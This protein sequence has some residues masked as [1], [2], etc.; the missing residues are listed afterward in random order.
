MATTSMQELMARMKAQK[1]AEKVGVSNSQPSSGEVK[2]ALMD[3]LDTVTDKPVHV[4]YIG[5]SIESSP[6]T[7]NHADIMLI[8]NRIIKLQEAMEKDIPEYASIL[9]TIH[10][11]LSKDDEL[12]H[13]M[14]EEEVGI[15]LRAMKLRK[16]VVLVEEKSKKSAKK[17]L[18]D[19]TLDDIL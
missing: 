16:N 4:D 12:T 5:E 7:L 10:K 2:T 11:A 18:K 1:A 14:D 6:K 9:H 3:K 19:T 13:M 17:S 8:K 15:L